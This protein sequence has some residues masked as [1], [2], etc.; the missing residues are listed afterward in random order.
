MHRVAFFRVAVQ[1]FQ[2]IGL[3]LGFIQRAILITDKSLGV[4]EDLVDTA[5]AHSGS[6]KDTSLIELS[7]KLTK[8]E[9][10][11]AAELELKP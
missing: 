3:A 9:R 7:T 2:T 6:F 10:A 11:A 4:A 8:A 5:K 1:F